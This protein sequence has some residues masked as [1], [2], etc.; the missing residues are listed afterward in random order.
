MDL[1]PEAVYKSDDQEDGCH[2]LTAQLLFL[3]SITMPTC[4]SRCDA[5]DAYHHK[6]TTQEHQDSTQLKSSG[7]PD[8]ATSGRPPRRWT[9]ELMS[10]SVC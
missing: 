2:K 8:E 6:S 5:V 7:L 10:Q 1:Q 4:L 3:V 9:T